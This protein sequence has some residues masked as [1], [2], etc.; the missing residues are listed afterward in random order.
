MIC[1]RDV[2]SGNKDVFGS[3]TSL[4]KSDW[5][6][7][8]WICLENLLLV[9]NQESLLY[10]MADFN[11]IISSLNIAWPCLRSSCGENMSFQL[12]VEADAG[13]I[14]IMS[15]WEKTK[16]AFLLLPGSSFPCCEL[17]NVNEEV[18]LI[19]RVTATVGYMS[20]HWGEGRSAGKEVVA[21]VKVNW[22]FW[23]Q[24]KKKLEMYRIISRS[25]SCWS[26]GN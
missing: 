19:V 23:G 15:T 5:L 1:R 24:E 9:R 22:Q 10:S 12:L 13:H 26:T 7:I 8:S 21:C 3:G 16:R 20:N 2:K 17:E 6:R 11:Q 18:D 25:Y 14:S 4:G